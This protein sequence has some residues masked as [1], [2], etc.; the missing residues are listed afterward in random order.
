MDVQGK[1]YNFRIITLSNYLRVTT[2]LF[3]NITIT[4]NSRDFGRVLSYC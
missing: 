3:D 2:N 1:I 4:V